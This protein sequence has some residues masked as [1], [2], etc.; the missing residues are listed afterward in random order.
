[1]TTLLATEPETIAA[2]TDIDPGYAWYLANRHEIVE[3]ETDDFL[4]T[5]QQLESENDLPAGT[6][7]RF[8]A[9]HTDASNVPEQEQ[10]RYMATWD[11]YHEALDTDSN[12]ATL[13]RVYGERVFI[14]IY[15]RIDATG[16]FTF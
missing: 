15:D 7:E 9:I 8:A 4:R 13:A 5:L 11:A 14:P 16:A 2:P 6:A 10:S 3:I 1:M 12:L